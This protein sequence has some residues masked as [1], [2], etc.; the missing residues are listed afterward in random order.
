MMFFLRGEVGVAPD[1]RDAARELADKLRLPEP[2]PDHQVERLDAFVSEVVKGYAVR[3]EDA[4][5]LCGLVG[6]HRRGLAVDAFEVR[7]DLRDQAT[8]AFRRWARA[9]DPPHEMDFVS[10][11]ESQRLLRIRLQASET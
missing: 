6:F 11:E 7:E 5:Y 1:E 10:Y 4:Y 3:Q 2:R 9:L 8:A